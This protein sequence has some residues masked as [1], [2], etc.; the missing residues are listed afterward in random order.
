MLCFF[1]NGSSSNCGVQHHLLRLPPCSSFSPC[2]LLYTNSLS[3]TVKADSF[4]QYLGRIWVNLE[5]RGRERDL[6]K[7]SWLIWS[8]PPDWRNIRANMNSQAHNR[9]VRM[10]ALYKQC[11]PCGWVILHV[12]DTE[13]FKEKCQFFVPFNLNYV[14]LCGI[15]VFNIHNT[16]DSYFQCPRAIRWIR[17]PLK[18]MAGLKLNCVLIYK[19]SMKNS[20]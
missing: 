1:E 14:L 18:L 13:Q 15:N 5:Q 16:I 11:L 7:V 6:N 17:G 12:T 3:I 10:W 19:C 4:S 2:P 8:N 9:S 20:T